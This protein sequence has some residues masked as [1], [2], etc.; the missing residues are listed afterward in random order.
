MAAPF[1]GAGGA[2]TAAAT[3]RCFR[4]GGPVG[5]SNRAH[6]GAV[7]RLAGRQSGLARHKTALIS[8][9]A[10]P[11]A[12]DY[13]RHPHRAGLG[14]LNLPVPWQREL[15]ASNMRGKLGLRPRQRGLDI[16]PD[17]QNADCPDAQPR[18]SGR[19][20]VKVKTYG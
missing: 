13:Q 4:G 7:G 1:P 20:Y 10:T 6:N 8:G 3:G 9:A 14:V 11:R 2:T 18:C 17:Y 12:A 5:G 15:G 19:A 16:C